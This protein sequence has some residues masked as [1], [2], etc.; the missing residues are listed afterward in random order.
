MHCIHLRILTEMLTKYDRNVVPKVKGVDVDVELLIQKI[1]EINEL[2]S[3][4]KMDILF[5][6][7][8][9][10]PGLSFEV[11]S[12]INFRYTE[13]HLERRGRKMLAK[14]FALSSNGRHP[15][16]PQRVFGK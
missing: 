6:Q 14:S 4:S 3:A 8:W 9:H 12:H 10:D 7:I 5:S 16:A 1:S 15:V 2:Y 11:L 13:N